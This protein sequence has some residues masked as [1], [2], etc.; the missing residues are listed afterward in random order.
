MINSIWHFSWTVRD[1]ETSVAFY[2]E[3][4]GL[5][6]VHR[7]RQDND[8]TRR[9]VNMPDAVLEVAMLRVPGHPTAVSGHHIELVQYISPVGDPIDTN[10]SNP[11][12]PHIAF[13]VDDI[14]EMID[15]LHGTQPLPAPIDVVEGRNTGGR[16]IYLRDPDGVVI[17][18]VQPPPHMKPNG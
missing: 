15:R 4:L 10:T 17:E 12:V 11:G 16:V 7:Q 3:R 5:E 14:D 13:A 2:T 1:I 8:Y 9:L 6:L 18:F